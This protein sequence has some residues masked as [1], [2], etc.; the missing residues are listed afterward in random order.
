MLIKKRTSCAAWN[1]GN[2]VVGLQNQ[3]GTLASVPAGRNTGN[4]SAV[5]E[6]WRFL[7]NGDS[8]TTLTWELN[9]VP[10]STNNPVTVCPA[11]GDVFQAIVKYTG[12]NGVDTVLM[13]DITLHIE[14]PLPVNNPINLSACSDGTGSAIFDLTQNNAVILNGLNPLDYN[15]IYLSTPTTYISNANATTFVSSGQTVYVLIE[16]YTTTGCY[17][18]KPFNLIINP[19]PVVPSGDPIQLFTSGETLANI[20]L[21]GTNIQW[22]SDENSSVVLPNSTVLVHGTTYYASQSNNFDC[23]SGKTN[24]GR[25]AV[26]VYDVA[27]NASSFDMIGFSTYPNPVKDVLNLSY[28]KAMSTVSIH[29]LLGQTVLTNKINATQT[30]IDM[31][32]LSSGTY[33]VKITVDGL[34]KTIKVIKE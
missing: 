13:D 30:K 17:I 16:D 27:L 33:L 10:F 23:V 3:A 25:F 12:C 22:Y 29:N 14:P 32:H 9:G 26:T 6:A 24:A 11:E 7:P 4:W 31:S 1:S 34:I 5:N 18:I 21:T 19:I 15:V 2:A 20:E 8:N 28:T